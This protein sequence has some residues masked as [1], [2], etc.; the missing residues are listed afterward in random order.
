MG[1][2]AK[3]YAKLAVEWYKHLY[4]FRNK[5]NPDNYYCIDY[6]DLVKDPGETITKVY[7]HFEWPVSNA[8]RD[9]LANATQRQREFK[10]KH[11]YTLA[12]F[13]LSR[14]WIQEELGEILDAYG[15]E[16]ETVEDAV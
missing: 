2:V 9:K 4:A 12:E 6:R 14:E 3:A 16:R 10:S 8:F 5:V 13:G 15:L 1:R 11:E 7:E